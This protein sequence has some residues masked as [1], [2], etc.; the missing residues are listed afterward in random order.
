MLARC[1]RVIE[2]HQTLFVIAFSV[3]FCGAVAG[4]GTLRSPPDAVQQVA[5]VEQ[6]L[7]VDLVAGDEGSLTCRAVPAAEEPA[8]LMVTGDPKSPGDDLWSGG[9]IWVDD[10]LH[11][12]DASVIRVVAEGSPA[13]SIPVGIGGWSVLGSLLAGLLVSLG[14]VALAEWRRS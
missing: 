8:T 2:R 13:L 14:C 11:N 4:L 1:L 12:E 7:W 5:E 6:P 3:A 10:P 9:G